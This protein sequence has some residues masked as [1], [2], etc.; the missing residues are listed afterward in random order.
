MGG[1]MA[2]S[3]MSVD[4]YLPA[5]PAIAHDLHATAAEVSNTLAVFL[6]ASWK[7]R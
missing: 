4:M 7:Q 5:F 1:I 2:I 3:P 6:L